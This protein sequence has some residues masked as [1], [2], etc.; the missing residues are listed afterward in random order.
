MPLS[1]SRMWLIRAVGRGMIVLFSLTAFLHANRVS[2]AYIL[3]E[4]AS[5]SRVFS[6][7]SRLEVS[8][9]LETAVGGGKAV[10]LK[11]KVNASHKYRERRLTGTG[12]D[13]EAFRS[14]RDYDDAAAKIEVDQQITSA[15]LPESRTLLVAY[16]TREGVGFYCPTGPMSYGE[17]ELLRMP[18]DSLAGLAL[19]PPKAVSVGEKWST[20]S[21]VIQMITGTEA[22]LKSDLTCEL[23]SVRADVAKVK[24]QGRIEGATAGAASELEISGH[25][26]FDLK[27]KYLKRLEMTQKEK[28][29][30][31]SVTP[32]VDVVAKIVFDRQPEKEAG[33]LNDALIAKIPLEP[34]ES[35]MLLRFRSPWNVGFLYDRN[36]HVFHQSDQVAV[37][38]LLDKGSLIAQ[39]NVEKIPSARPRKQTSEAQFQQDIRTKLG[40]NLEEIV[41]AELLKS[42]DKRFRY[43]VTAIG[44]SNKLSMTWIYY[45]CVAPSGRQVAL[46]FSVETK[47]LK[48]LGNRDLGIVSTLEFFQPT[49]EPTKATR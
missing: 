44:E 39:C 29:S 43:R 4:P 42:D 15:R 14:L 48:Q 46:V 38:R 26:L 47:L 22:V 45:L 11:L 33:R 5:D 10:A 3:E 17:L 16:G 9:Q 41:K 18:G 31:G 21:W 1:F 40:G 28:R 27:G 2:A 35:V 34:D 19:L 13:A 49:I 7:N 23:Q 6:V 20:S 37:L 30:V 24:F 36:W 12:R 25:Y 8:G 32:G